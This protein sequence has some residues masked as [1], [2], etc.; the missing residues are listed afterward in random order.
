LGSGEGHKIK[1][2][3]EVLLA[4][5]PKTIEVEQDPARMTPSDVPKLI[6]NRSKFGDLTGWKPEVGFEETLGRVLDYFRKA[7]KVTSNK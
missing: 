4:L 6:C 1:E 3:L 7:S 5:S 2:V